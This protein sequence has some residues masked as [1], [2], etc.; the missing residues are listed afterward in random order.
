MNPDDLARAS[1]HADTLFGRAQDS[2]Y[3][4]N[5]VNGTVLVDTGALVHQSYDIDIWLS[6]TANLGGDYL[7]IQWRNAANTADIWAFR[8]MF[9]ASTTFHMRLQN[10]YPALSER[11]RV[12]ATGNIVGAISSAMY[13]V[14]RTA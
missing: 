12:I 10:F 11:V 3:D 2:S 7:Q 13:W 4:I 6:D 14:Q 9:L 5:P 8:V 1:L